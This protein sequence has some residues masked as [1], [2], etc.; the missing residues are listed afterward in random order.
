MRQ[1]V[2]IGRIAGFHQDRRSAAR[3]LADA[4]VE[5]EDGCLE[6]GQP[7]KLLHQVVLRDHNEKSAHHQ[8]D[9]DKVVPAVED[10]GNRRGHQLSS[11]D[12]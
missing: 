6:N 9:N 4:D 3:H 12:L 10:H 8:A 11:P 2:G 5:Q 1:R 7:D